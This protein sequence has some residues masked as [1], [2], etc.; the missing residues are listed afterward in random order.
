MGFQKPTETQITQWVFWVSITLSGFRDL[1]LDVKAEQ[2]GGRGTSQTVWEVDLA[3]DWQRPKVI[4]AERVEFKTKEKET[5]Q[6]KDVYKNYQETVYQR[7]KEYQTFDR[8][9]N[10]EKFYSVYR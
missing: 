3:R 5:W 7:Q 4:V 9:W 2:A 10:N 8:H 1:N 6:T